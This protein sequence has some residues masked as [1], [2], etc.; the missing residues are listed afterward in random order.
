MNIILT[1]F[2]GTGKSVA[3]RKL[4]RRLDWPFV[5]IDEQIEKSAG[6]PIAAIFTGHGES[7]FRRLE[8]RAIHR[9]V[10]TP[11][12]VIATGGGAF[13]DQEN[14]R[15]LRGA[16]RPSAARQGLLDLTDYILAP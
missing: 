14:P 16:G 2:M 8:K 6:L 9:A 3:G 5:D 10:R 12:Q 15:L 1:G 13:V 4:A 7:V 11:G